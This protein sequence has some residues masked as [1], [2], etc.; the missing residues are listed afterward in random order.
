MSNDWRFISLWTY[1]F[2]KNC[3]KDFS[4]V[5]VLLRNDELCFKQKKK[6]PI[7]DIYER[8]KIIQECKYV[9]RVI[10]DT[11]INNDELND[12][13]LKPYKIDYV[14][15]AHSEN[16][17]NIYNNMFKNLNTIKFI[18]YDYTNTISTTT[19]IKRIIQRYNNNKLNLY[20]NPLKPTKKKIAIIGIF[21]NNI[22]LEKI[23]Q[24]FISDDIFILYI[25]QKNN[26][27]QI[28]ILKNCKFINSYS[29]FKENIYEITDDYIN[30]LKI[31]LLIY[32]LE[33]YDNLIQ[34]IKFDKKYLFNLIL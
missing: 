25:N 12:E 7:L 20:D 13:L 16:E 14:A 21:N 23:K 6:Y 29:E 19:L 8:E 11:R 26:H 28:N 5:Y 4:K 18:R 31:N 22:F 15:H 10:I 2:L 17:D 1:K 34:K 27:K 9:D 32:N 24:Y 30:N 3:K 33:S